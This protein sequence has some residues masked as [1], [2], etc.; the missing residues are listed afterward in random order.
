MQSMSHRCRRRWLID[1]DGC[2]C[3]RPK[4]EKK[5]R[6]KSQVGV[7]DEGGGASDYD[8]SAFVTQGSQRVTASH[9]ELHSTQRPS[10]RNCS[11]SL[12]DLV[13]GP[14]STA[15]RPDIA[16]AG[17]LVTMCPIRSHRGQAY[18]PSSPVYKVSPSSFKLG[19][20]TSLYSGPPRYALQRNAI[21][22]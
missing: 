6:E 9:G 11:L 17:V 12:R 8:A 3:G 2:P 20:E 14:T 13:F 16:S 21:S 5:T 1:A 10:L 19:R 7:A 22:S 4:C 15:L 18:R